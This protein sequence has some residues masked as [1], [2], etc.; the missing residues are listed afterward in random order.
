MEKNKSKIV[1]RIIDFASKN[2]ISLSALEDKIGASRSYF[3]N[4][5]IH[6]RGISTDRLESFIEEVPKLLYGQQINI[7]WLVTGKGGMF[8]NTYKAISATNYVRETT[9]QDEF[10]EMLLVGLE[11]EEVK[12]RLKEIMSEMAQ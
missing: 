3:K 4:A 2:N 5:V 11:N 10:E 12:A 1:E 9:E 6:N 8:K 7:E